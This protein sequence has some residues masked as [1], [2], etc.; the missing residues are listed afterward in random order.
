MAMIQGVQAAAFIQK[1]ELI[2]AWKISKKTKHL[3]NML[4]G[5]P[6]VLH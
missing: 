2:R 4:E 3:N 5:N 6:P 1:S